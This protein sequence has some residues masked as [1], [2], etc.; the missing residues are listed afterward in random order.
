[1]FGC[2]KIETKV[3]LLRIARLDLFGVRLPECLRWS[4]VNHQSE[5]LASHY[6]TNSTGK[7]GT[8]RNLL[9]FCTWWTW[10]SSDCGDTTIGHVPPVH[11]RCTANPFSHYDS[12]VVHHLCHF[13]DDD[14]MCEFRQKHYYFGIHLLLHVDRLSCDQFRSDVADSQ[15]NASGSPG[16]RATIELSRGDLFSILARSIGALWF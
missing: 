1:M 8:W 2:L 15:F 10:A 9:L 6:R 5:R 3:P 13:Y 7:W 16:R 14:V 12:S 11:N 4:F